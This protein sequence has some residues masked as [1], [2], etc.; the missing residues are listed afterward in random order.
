MDRLEAVVRGSHDRIVTT[1]VPIAQAPE[2]S[3]FGIDMT[4][5]LETMSLGERRDTIS[6]KDSDFNLGVEGP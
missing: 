5:L 6:R 3:G 4:I 1:V 2:V